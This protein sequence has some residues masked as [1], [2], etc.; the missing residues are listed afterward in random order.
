MSWFSE[1]KLYEINSK[2]NYG[3]NFRIASLADNDGRDAEN[4]RLAKTQ[5]IQAYHIR[6]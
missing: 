1:N 6:T 3:L 5:R 4:T 2:I